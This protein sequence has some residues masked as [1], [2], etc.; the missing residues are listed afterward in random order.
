M[1]NLPQI[2]LTFTDGDEWEEFCQSCLKIKHQHN[3]F[4]S[5]P[6]D[7]G[8][9]DCGLDGFNSIGDAYQCYCPEKE[10]T[11]KELYEHQRDKVTTDIQKLYDYKVKLK[12]ILNGNKIK[13]WHFT[14]P[15]L[16]SKQL[17]HH[18]NTKEKLVKSWN[19]DFIDDDFQIGLKD[20]EYF[21]PE[22]PL[23]ISSSKV[24]YPMNSRGIDFPAEEPSS[25]LIEDYKATYENNKFV[26]NGLR[27]NEKLFSKVDGK[28]YA[29]NIIKLTDSNIEYNIIGESILKLWSNAYDKQYE[30]FVRVR[31][32]LE[33]RIKHESLIPVAN[34]PEKLKEIKEIVKE[35][36][37]NEFPHFLSESNKEELTSYLVSY[38]VLECSL[39]FS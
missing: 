37:N 13:T 35:A 15:L 11:D 25:Q 6:A 38:W 14:T 36:L 17:I 18:C 5:V 34:N 9:G 39:D 20:Y 21:L 3:N 28:D 29:E 24:L 2:G 1:I 19:L 4:K 12:K 10:Y 30:K 32:T 22:I 7:D 26:E 23:V 16:K 31:K 27:K 8:D 33:K